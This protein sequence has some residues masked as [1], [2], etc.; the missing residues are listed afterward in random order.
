MKV[1]KY[2]N[3]IIVKKK[4]KRTKVITSPK[5]PDNNF[6]QIKAYSKEGKFAGFKEER[7]IQ[8]V[9][10]HLTDE[11]LELLAHMIIHHLTEKK[12]DRSAKTRSTQ[13]V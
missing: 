10:I 11:T 5:N 3:G 7:G 6:V 4:N 12:N 9:T 2:T 8:T 13:A 1:L